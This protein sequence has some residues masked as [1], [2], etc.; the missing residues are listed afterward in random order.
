MP[1]RSPTLAGLLA[2]QN[3]VVSRQQLLQARLLS[4][5]A[6]QRRLRAAGPWQVLVEGVYGAFTGTPTR[7]QVLRASLLYAGDDAFLTAVTGCEL[8][9]LRK[10][11][12]R[13]PGEVVV[14]SPRKLESVAIA[15]TTVRFIRTRRS[16]ETLRVN[17]LPVGRIARCIVDAALLMRDLDDVCALVAE[18]VRTRRVDLSDLAA[19]LVQ[20]PRQGSANLRCAMTSIRA[21]AR[22]AAEAKQV[23]LTKRSRILPPLHYN[24]SLI[25]PDGFIA[26]P[27]AY[28][29]ESGVA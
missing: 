9:D 27:D 5:S 13:V 18:A 24:C 11:R 20:A 14:G 28:A 3:Q 22:S 12:G 6:I 19:E 21:G 25:G 1:S 10:A 16:V 23:R 2:A 8:H 29:E 26:K 4:R 15:G 7:Q 17:G